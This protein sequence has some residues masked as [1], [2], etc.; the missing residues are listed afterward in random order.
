MRAQPTRGPTERLPVAHSLQAAQLLF[1]VVADSMKPHAAA[2]EFQECG[3][4]W[5]SC[6]TFVRHRRRAARLIEEQMDDVKRMNQMALYSKCV[7]I[8][9]AQIEER[10]HVLEEALEEERRLDVMMEARPHSQHPKQ[11]PLGSE[12]LN[13][14]GRP[15]SYSSGLAHAASCLV[16]RCLPQLD[17]LK[18]VDTY[19]ERE[20]KRKEEQR[21]GA[22]VLAKQISD[23]ES[24]RLREEEM[25]DRERLQA[26]FHTRIRKSHKRT[27]AC[28]CGAA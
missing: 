15:P 12:T 23:R 9:D 16:L 5:R 25:R 1:I 20:R 6:I 2:E 24:E 18:A 21:K 22:A 11:P 26:H 14:S 13:P 17:R 3:H 27:S 28:C 4:L 8:R 19:D 10:R 7:T